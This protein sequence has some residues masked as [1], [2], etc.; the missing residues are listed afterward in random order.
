MTAHLTSLSKIAEGWRVT[1]DCGWTQDVTKRK[2]DPPGTRIK[3]RAKQ[4]AWDHWAT[5]PI[6][7]VR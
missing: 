3:E 5:M 6:G 7:G 4:A 1:C 2:E